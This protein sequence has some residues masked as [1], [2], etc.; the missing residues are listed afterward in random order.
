MMNNYKL[1]CMAPDGDYVTDIRYA[2]VEECTEAS[3]DMGSRWIFYPYHFICSGKT[4]RVAPDGLER[5]QGKRIT[6]IQ[7]I[8]KDWYKRENKLE[9]R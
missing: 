3:A 4:I 8:F 7:R 9:N 6:T 5:F 2:S 1:I